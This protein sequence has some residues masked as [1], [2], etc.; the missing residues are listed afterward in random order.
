MGQRVQNLKRYMSANQ[1]KKIGQEQRPYVS[2]ERHKS[3]IKFTNAGYPMRDY[4]KEMRD[5]R[6][7]KEEL[8]QIEME[9]LDKKGLARQQYLEKMMNEKEQPDIV[10][11]LQQEMEMDKKDLQSRLERGGLE[12]LTENE[13]A[14]LKVQEEIK[15]E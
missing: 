5:E 11:R 2:T 14:L 13:K 8:R 15:E 3:K 9:Q 7:E 1:N 10:T 12:S 4:V 6:L